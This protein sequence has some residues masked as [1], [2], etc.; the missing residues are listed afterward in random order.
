MRFRGKFPPQTPAERQA[1]CRAI[2][3]GTYHYC[4]EVPQPPL[5]PGLP[6]PTDP[7]LLPHVI[8]EQ[9]RLSLSAPAQQALPPPAAPPATAA[10][11][12]SLSSDGR[13]LALLDEGRGGEEWGD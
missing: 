11:Q 3:R 8:A 1:K 10:I 5:P 6:I 12:K 9:Q 13:S 7:N 2:K 4:Q